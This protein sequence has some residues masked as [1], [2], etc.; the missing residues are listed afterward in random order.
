MST[1]YCSNCNQQV[2][3]HRKIGIDTLIL[4]L[5]TSFIWIIFIPFYSKRC[6]ICKGVNFK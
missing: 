5:I 4:C 2:T 3:P 6:P 1:K